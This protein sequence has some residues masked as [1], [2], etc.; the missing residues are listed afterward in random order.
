MVQD[1]YNN[2]V[3]KKKKPLIA[4]GSTISNYITML[5]IAVNMD[6][7]AC[8]FIFNKQQVINLIIEIKLNKSL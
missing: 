4:Q 6:V 1:F 5:K 7:N 3:P 8:K 2:H